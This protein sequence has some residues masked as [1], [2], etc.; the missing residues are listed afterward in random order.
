M[1]ETVQEATTIYSG[2]RGCAIKILN[3]IE[4][5]DAYL[6]K[7]L[8]IEL[9]AG[10][11]SNVDKSLLAEIVHGVIRWQGKLDW[12]LNRFTHG[13]FS[14]T[15]IN[16]RNALRVGLYQILFL[17]R[18]PHYA[19]VNEAVEFA[20]RIRGEKPGSF[21]NGVLRNIIRNLET[22]HYPKIEEDALQHFSVFYSHPSWLVKRWLGRFST[23]ELEKFLSANNEIPS[24]TLRVNKLKIA[25][26][27]FLSQLDEAKIQYQGSSFID[28]FIK[29]RHLG[30]IAQMDSFRLGHF[31]IQDESA[32]LP[33]LLLAP[34]PGE[35]VIDLCAAP[36]GKTTMLSE[37]MANQGE[38]L[39][40]DKYEHKL[41]LLKTSL[42]RLGIT[43]VQL[44]VA[45]ATQLDSIQAEKVLVDA[46]CSGLGVLRKKPDIKW[47]RQPEDIAK[48][49]DLQRRILD[50]AARL[51]APGGVLVY[52]TCTTEPEENELMVKDFLRRHEEFTIDD[53]SRF[54]NKSVVTPEGFITTYP[55][56]HH[57]DGSFAARLQKKGTA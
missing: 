25:P 56:Q 39:A 7:L 30:G 48:L 32:A 21:V 27:A 34:K 46:P 23:A 33:V 2:P 18:L 19:A 44:V 29:V 49:A 16:I 50:N 8:D 4:R 37:L 43:N 15:E 14:K 51:V 35:R 24:L 31:S 28:Y 52:S 20:K 6:D 17:D 57:L 55:H 11:L 9:K 41:Q 13:N 42:D 47:K 10:D 22:L 38:V 40:V 26:L 54:V 36:G 5:S 3:R 12:V 45:D 53:A 1:S